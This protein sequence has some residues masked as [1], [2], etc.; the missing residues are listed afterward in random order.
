MWHSHCPLWSPFSWC[1]LYSSGNLPVSERISAQDLLK[2]VVHALSMIHTAMLHIIHSLL[3]AC[4]F[5]NVFVLGFMHLN[6]RNLS[7][8]L[9][10]Y[11]FIPYLGET[12]S[13]L[14]YII[15]K[16]WCRGRRGRGRSSTSE[17]AWGQ[18]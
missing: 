1:G 8:L 6:R 11:G 15:C 13:R 9:P 7:S 14:L 4:R 16:R 12:L 17:R 10:V 18:P 5:G 3:I 2:H